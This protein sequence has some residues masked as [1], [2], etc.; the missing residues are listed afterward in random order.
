MGVLIGEANVTRFSYL[1]YQAIMVCL[2]AIICCGLVAIELTMNRFQVL[3]LLF[4]GMFSIRE[5]KFYFFDY[6][7]DNG[8]M[9]GR[10]R[11]QAKML[12]RMTLCVVLSYLWQYCVMDTGQQVGTEFPVQE[13]REEKDCFASNLHFITLF[14]RQYTPVDCKGPQ[15]A[16]P[17]R[18]VV[19][20]IRFVQPSASKWLMHLAISHSITQ[21]NLKAFEI[22]VWVAG[23]SP[24]MRRLIGVM[25]FISLTVCL[26][27]FFA[28]ILSEFASSWLSFVTI[29]SV[30]M[31][32]HTVY[33][34]AK[35][36]E[37][38]WK[39]ESARVQTSIESHL[40]SAL[41]EFGPP[42]VSTEDPEVG[43]GEAQTGKGLNRYRNML[44]FRGFPHIMSSRASRSS[45]STT[46]I[47]SPVAS[48]ECGH[49]PNG[50]GCSIQEGSPRL[51]LE[52]LIPSASGGPR[53]A[54]GS[55]EHPAQAPTAEAAARAAGQRRGSGE[56]EHEVADG[57][58]PEERGA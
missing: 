35:V 12:M 11:S 19:S 27:L 23:N 29:L 54:Q 18:V 5:R 41:S 50:Q 49:G 25:I 39:E 38:L 20:C 45:W 33:Q 42:D 46:Q 57:A 51:P 30:P 24:R 1:E 32:F 15:E 28:G 6:L 21:L 26:G 36:L 47:P 56:D 34:G 52:P 31:F 55:Q 7:V 17:S 48:S 3:P 44:K 58:E 16:F 9:A 14:N 22:L 53:P 40:N 37:E 13:C 2:A 8:P 4:P 43:L 10:L